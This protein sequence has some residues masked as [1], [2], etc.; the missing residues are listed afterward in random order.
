MMIRFF[1]SA[2][3]FLGLALALV[4]CE[5]DPGASS[6]GEASSGAQ[7]NAD[8]G[9]TSMGYQPPKFGGGGY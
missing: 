7:S 1:G 5:T 8:T 6:A 9:S 2:V 4:A 3:I